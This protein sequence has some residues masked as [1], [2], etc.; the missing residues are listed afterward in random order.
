MDKN[1]FIELTINLYRATDIFSD[2]EPLKFLLRKK[3]NEILE[4]ISPHH[5]S[6][7]STISFEESEKL[8]KMIQSL[9]S[10]LKVAE[11][12]EEGDQ[13]TFFFLTGEYERI[14][15]ELGGVYSSQEV[16][17]THFYHQD[18]FNRKNEEIN[19]NKDISHGEEINHGDIKT[20]EVSITGRQEKILSL[21]RHQPNL[22]VNKM[23]QNFSGITT[24]TIRRDLMGLLEKGLL[25]KRK[26][27]K[28][29]FYQV[30]P[31]D[32]F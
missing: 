26:D 14:E 8:G 4:E 13:L 25:K 7:N 17:E 9:K 22:D 2:E 19:H 10:L 21:L 23:A 15:K 6:E 5:F 16:L 1:Y 30:K 18:G 29:I 32:K 20:K 28:T 27:G 3:S 11:S 12:R 24:R 31:V